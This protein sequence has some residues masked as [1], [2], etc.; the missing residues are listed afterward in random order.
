MPLEKLALICVGVLA[1]IWIIVMLGGIV[2]T[3]PYGLPALVILL[4]VGY[5]LYR[6]IKDRLTNAEDDYYEK[7]V[8]Q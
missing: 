3:L 8:R 2:A 5:F 4:G 7:N 6:V 1:A